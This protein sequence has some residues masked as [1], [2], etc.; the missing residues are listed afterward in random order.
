[1][2]NKVEK[3]SVYNVNE[4]IRKYSTM[5]VRSML[6]KAMIIAMQKMHLNEIQFLKDKI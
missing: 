5:H 3:M 6:L 4:N 2:I 1:V